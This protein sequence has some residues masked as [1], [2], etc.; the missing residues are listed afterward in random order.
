[1]P[2]RIRS[3]STSCSP[4]TVAARWTIAAPAVIGWSFTTP[5][6][7]CCAW[8]SFNSQAAATSQAPGRCP[9]SPSSRAAI[10]SSGC[11][12][13]IEW[14]SPP[15]RSAHPRRRCHL[16]RRSS[17]P[18]PSGNTLCHPA[19]VDWPMTGR[20]WSLATASLRL[21]KRALATAMMM[22]PP[23]CRSAPDWFCCGTRF[24]C[25]NGRYRSRW[26]WRWIMTT[27]LSPI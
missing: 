3:G 4:R 18:M 19:G 1:M 2:R 8:P 6:T 20:R 13:R 27:A 10:N 26:C 25:R 5:A 24:N 15:R 9:I 17:R 14:P 21:A 22:T 7:R 12:G 11:P 16:S 23:S